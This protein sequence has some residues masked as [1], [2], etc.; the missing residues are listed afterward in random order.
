[1]RYAHFVLIT[2]VLLASC[3]SREQVDKAKYSQWGVIDKSSFLE[4]KSVELD[5]MQFADGNYRFLMNGVIQ[6]DDQQHRYSILMKCSPFVGGTQ[7]VISHNFPFIKIDSDTFTC[8][9]YRAEKDLIT[10]W[11]SGPKYLR[12]H[13]DR[14]LI[15]AR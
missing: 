10:E 3:S 14:K 5:S 4:L 15:S 11:V 1:M 7:N 2:W 6:V 12:L 13:I 8:S 9:V